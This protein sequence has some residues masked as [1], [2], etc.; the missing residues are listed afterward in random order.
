MPHLGF[1]VGPLLLLRLVAVRLHS[2]IGR[3]G[4][5]GNGSRSLWTMLR[6]AEYPQLSIVWRTGQKETIGMFNAGLH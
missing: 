6:K 3:F 4:L 1:L 2:C 5:F